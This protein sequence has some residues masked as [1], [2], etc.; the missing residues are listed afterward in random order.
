MSNPELIL[1]SVY[2]IE[3]SQVGMWNEGHWNYKWSGRS[4]SHCSSNN[5]IMYRYEG[6]GIYTVKDHL[7]RIWQMDQKVFASK[8]S[9]KFI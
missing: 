7:G 4:S 2:T 9:S 8:V 1:D 6:D 3:P 5:E